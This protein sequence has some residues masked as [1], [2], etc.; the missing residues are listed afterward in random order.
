[1]DL[2]WTTYKTLYNHKVPEFL[3]NIIVLDGDVRKQ[4]IGWKKYPKNKNILFL[5]TLMA[6]ERIVYETLYSLDPEDSFWD[7]SLSGYSKDVCFRNFP[8]HLDDIDSIKEWFNEQKSNAGKAYQKFIKVW[9]KTHQ[10]EIKIFVE[11]FI[12]AYNY[13]AKRVGSKPIKKE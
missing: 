10:D 12:K 6:P 11:D 1:M 7:N 13:V 8:S 5:P 2:S 9:S 3:N 4:D